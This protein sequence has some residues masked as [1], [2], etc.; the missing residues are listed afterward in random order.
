MINEIN[1]WQRFK[2]DIKC[3]FD[4]DPAAIYGNMK[5]SGLRASY[6]CLVVG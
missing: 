6:L 5:L 2:E 1:A 3:V 4:R